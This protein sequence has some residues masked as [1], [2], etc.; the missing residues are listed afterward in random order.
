MIASCLVKDPSK[1]PSAEKLLKHPFFKQ[2]RSGDYIV[3][4]LLDGLPVL[5]DRLQELKRK[6]E[7]ML[8]QKKIPDGEKEEISQNEYK[9]GISAWN[10]D[11][12]DM[13]AQASLIQDEDIVADKDQKGSIGSP[14]GGKFQYQFSFTSQCS[15]SI[16]LGDNN[17]SALP[18]SA[19]STCASTVTK[20]EKSDDEV[21]IASSM[22][23]SHSHNSSNCSIQYLSDL[24]INSAGKME[25]EVKGKSPKKSKIYCNQSDKSHIQTQ[26]PSSC[27]CDFVLRTFCDM[28]SENSSRTS[29]AS[30]NS[31]ELDEKAKSP[32]VQQRGRFKVTS[33]NVDFEKVG[34]PVQKS[35]SMQHPAVVSSPVLPTDAAP[36]SLSK[37]SLYPMFQSLLQSNILQREYIL[38]LMKQLAIGDN[39]TVNQAVDGG[40]CMSTN[41]TASEKSMLELAHDREKDLLREITDLQRRYLL[42][43]TFL[44]LSF[45]HILNFG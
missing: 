40:G 23:Y 41:T 21:S 45:A 35:H 22:P 20:G 34:S 43:I 19:D 38:G 33:G 11:L 7:A 3:R 39:S 31:D 32:V 9:R 27:N 37:H 29:K 36:H 12:E 15:D 18:I 1:R 26:N 14:Q 28:P 25:P 17:Q 42:C 2:A 16:E 13:K 10:F 44:S 5:G 4:A 6:D 8:A 30:V 24:E